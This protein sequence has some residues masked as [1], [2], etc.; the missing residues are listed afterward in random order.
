[1]LIGFDISAALDKLLTDTTC[2][3]AMIDFSRF[4]NP[5]DIVYKYTHSIIT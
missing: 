2:L 3:C 4:L 5:V 1:M